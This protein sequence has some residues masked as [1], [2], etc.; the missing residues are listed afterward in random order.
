MKS[1]EITA[2]IAVS[3]IG[4][5]SIIFILIYKLRYKTGYWDGYENGFNVG[6]M[7]A[8]YSKQENDEK[9][10]RLLRDISVNK[11]VVKIK[12]KE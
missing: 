3:S 5:F 8:N 7:R 1:R 9:L 2:V 4:V 12:R 11:K 6:I 10:N